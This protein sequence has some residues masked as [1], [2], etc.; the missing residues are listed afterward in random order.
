MIERINTR[1]LLYMLFA[2]ALVWEIFN[3]GWIAHVFVHPELHPHP[4]EDHQF[5]V[6]ST[7]MLMVVLLLFSLAMYNRK[8]LGVAKI[9]E[10]TFSERDLSQEK[11]SQSLFDINKGFGVGPR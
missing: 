11:K 3:F 4:L 10:K 9:N 6:G 5:V 7:T 2:A 8:L 1:I